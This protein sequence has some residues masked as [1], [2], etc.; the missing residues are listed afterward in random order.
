MK[1]INLLFFLCFVLL[2]QLGCTSERQVLRSKTLSRVMK[3]KYASSPI[4]VDGKL[5]EEVWGKT[6]T[7][8]MNLSV[9]SIKSNQLPQEPGE[10][11]L[12]W[13]ESFFYV[14]IV[15]YDSDIVAEGDK[16]QLNH[17]QLGDLCELF[18]K[19]AD[20][21]W[22]W[23]LYVTPRGNK[24]HYWFPGR[25]RLGLKSNRD[26]ECGLKVA[27]KC[28]GTLNNWKDLDQYWTAEMAM[29]ISDLTT[30]G[31]SFT[32]GSDWRILV[33]RYNYSKDLTESIGPELSM[34]PQL[35]RSAFHMFE[36]YAELKL[37]K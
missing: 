13:D 3:A 24:S 4:N 2:G 34:V 17:F 20:K 18:L 23:E 27:T 1:L 37:E 30:R 31:E 19:P 7:Y 32:S 6:E 12:A 35:S 22:Y 15:F 26:C 11:H 5:D 9:D 14:G 21:M 28:R 36:E 33:S 8:F 29:P 25:G 10:I 16:D